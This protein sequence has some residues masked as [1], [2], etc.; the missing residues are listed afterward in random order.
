MFVYTDLSVVLGFV[1]CGDQRGESR[2]SRGM[3]K[4]IIARRGYQSLSRPSLHDFDTLTLVSGDSAENH[5]PGVVLGKFVKLGITSHGSSFHSFR[6]SNQ[7]N[8]KKRIVELQF[9]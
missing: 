9:T 1:D 6:E 3:L 7:M 2:V 5:V 4:C 8:V